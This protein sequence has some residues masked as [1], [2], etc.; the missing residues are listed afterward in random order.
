M[1]SSIGPIALLGTS[2][3]P[4]TFGHQA[5]LKGLLTIFPKVVTWA[6]DNPMKT[7]VASLENRLALL[8]TLVTAIANPQLQVI[9]NLSSPWTITTLEKASALWP[10][11]ELV[12]VIGSDL[13]MQIPNWENPKAF[14]KKARIGIA[15]RKGWPL[16][17]LHL[18]TLKALGG[19]IDIL[20][21]QIP[22]SASST[23]RQHPKI[24]EIPD[25]ILPMVIEQNLYGLNNK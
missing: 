22:C 23:V 17:K 24:S 12:F 8:N 11:E 16:T 10:D 3:D 4:P 7:H 9:Q 20:P 6:S 13:V 19:E 1:T 25:S 2:A 14:M 5:L 15:P 18:E 21:L